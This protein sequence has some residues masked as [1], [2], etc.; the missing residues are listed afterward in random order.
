MVDLSDKLTVFLL[1]SH[2][3]INLPNVMEALQKQTVTFK[4]EVIENVTP[5][6]V[7]LQEMIIRCITPYYIQCDEDMVL[8]PD[9]I[10]IMFNTIQNNAEYFCRVFP[11]TEK[12]I[13]QSVYGIK[14]FNHDVMA[15]YSYNLN[16]LS[17]SVELFREMEK[18]G[19]KYKNESTVVG[20]HS[21][22]WTPETIYNRY[23]ILSKKIKTDIGSGGYG[24]LHK[25]FR[26]KLAIEFNPLDF[27]AM[28]GVVAA[29]YSNKPISYQDVANLFYY[30]EEAKKLRIGKV[31]D[32]FGWAFYFVA[33]EMAKY[34]KHTMTYEKYDNVHYDKL[35]IVLLSNPNI[36]TPISNI[37][38]PTTAKESGLKVVGQYC[39]EVQETYKY[40]DLIITISPQTYNFAKSKYTCPVIYLPESI[41]TQFFAVKETNLDS[42]I[43]G[44]AGREHVVKRT[45]L[46]EKLDYP[47]KKQAN[48]G[49]KYFNEESNS[50]PMLDFYHSIDC[51]VLTSA[52]E[53]QPRVV[54]EAMSCG[55]PVISTD[56]GSISML[57]DKEW[58]V[59]TIPEHTV[60]EE[61][62]KKL[63]MLSENPELRKNVG[64][65]NRTV[66]Y[67]NFSWEINQK[68][69][70]DVF[71][72]LYNNETDK[73]LDIHNMF[74][75]RYWRAFKKEPKYRYDRLSN[76]FIDIEKPITAQLGNTTLEG[77]LKL[78]QGAN[79]KFWGLQ[80]TC[81]Y[82]VN[83]VKKCPEVICV[84]VR[85]EEDKKKL[86]SIIP[87]G[88]EVIISPK[89]QTKVWKDNI[90]VPLPVV[91]YLINMFGPKWKD[92]TN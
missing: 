48:W 85:T 73:I 45:H 63:K 86:L 70:D 3:D 61:M 20:L 54:M 40:A 6:A 87:S 51:L 66:I 5:L 82:M 92:L 90:Y 67:K 31:I 83:G 26:E 64:K 30:N 44:W 89:Q 91:P 65:R 21:P 57:L 53:C 47:I 13:N 9:A 18:D 59:P 80:K 24:D 56:V 39:G 46:L 7:A 29:K 8:N 41:D 78:L 36:C 37:K 33:K 10:N 15:R 71:T 28:M 50:K 72:Y 55:L 14:I 4:L 23:Y 11:L 88:L 52:S 32:Q 19:L 79:V 35:D 68:Y 1:K 12:S 58:I 84:G 81:L 27:W 17:A 75:K 49:A 60:I 25:K 22:L 34:S 42:F 69:W 38:I 74:V 43:V 77:K 16:T 2:N 76:K 62:N